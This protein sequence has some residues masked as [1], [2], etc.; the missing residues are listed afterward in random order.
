M[1]ALAR[2]WITNHARDHNLMCRHVAVLTDHFPD[3]FYGTNTKIRETLNN[4]ILH[5]PQ[6]WQ[7]G[8]ALPFV[9]I[10]GTTVEWDVRAAPRTKLPHHRARPAPAP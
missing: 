8:V 1:C 5:S 4:L 6:E 2:I 10:Q 3:A 9:Q 7:T